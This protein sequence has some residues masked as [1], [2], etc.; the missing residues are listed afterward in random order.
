VQTPRR[1]AGVASGTDTDGDNMLD[2]REV[3]Y[4][5]TNPASVNTDGD[6]CHDQRE[7]NSVNENNAVDVIDLQ[8]VSA[9]ANGTYTLPGSAVKVDFDITKNA[10]VDVI[11]LG[12][13]AAAEAA[14][15]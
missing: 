3:C 8:A 2:Y 1:L 10:S 4:Y 6:P 14:C 13:V 12:I 11:D 9:E 7:F 15:P 5:N